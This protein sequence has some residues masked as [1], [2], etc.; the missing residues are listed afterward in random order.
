MS[1]KVQLTASEIINRRNEL[2]SLDK[3]QLNKISRDVLRQYCSGCLDYN[4]K[5][6]KADL[7]DKI[8]NWCESVRLERVAALQAVKD[9]LTDEIGKVDTNFIQELVTT[10]NPVEAAKQ[11]RIRMLARQY[12][13]STIVKTVQPEAIKFVNSLIDITDD[14]K[15][16]FEIALRKENKADNK[17]VNDDYRNETVPGYSEDR[18]IINFNEVLEW[19][20]T[21]LIEKKNWKLVTL[22][23]TLT[24]GRR[25]VEIHCTGEFVETVEPNHKLP[26]Y[27]ITQSWLSFT[28]Q[29]KEKA[30]MTTKEAKGTYTIPL[31]VDAKLWLEGYQYLVRNGKTGIEKK[32][33]NGS[34]SGEVGDSVKIRLVKFGIT[35]WYGCRD[36]YAASYRYAQSQLESQNDIKALKIGQEIVLSEILGHGEKDITSQQSYGKYSIIF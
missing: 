9:N 19:A 11:L 34:Y 15:Q 1:R 22:A 31:L 8:Y 4:S 21:Q 13:K 7:V 16:A 35:K 6:K 32:K 10:L 12:E 17:D 28:G 18:T 26:N 29:A 3:E 25:P 24:S 27:S 36:F 20:T 5:D 2:A 30:D 23:L 14:Y 33:L